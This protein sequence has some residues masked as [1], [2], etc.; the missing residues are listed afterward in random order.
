MISVDLDIARFIQLERN[1]PLNRSDFPIRRQIPFYLGR[2]AGIAGKFP[3]RMPVRNHVQQQTDSERFPGNNRI[4]VRN[5][6][7]FDQLAT[8]VSL[9]PRGR[10]EMDH[11]CQKAAVAPKKR[12]IVK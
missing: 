8:F 4:G 10:T 5:Q 3:I 1:R 12:P 6:F 2:N 11:Q 7:R 9:T